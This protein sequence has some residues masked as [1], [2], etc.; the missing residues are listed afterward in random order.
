VVDATEHQLAA[1]RGGDKEARGA[2]LERLR[3]RLVL[4]ASSRMSDRLRARL[5]AEDA[6]Q[7]ILLALHRSLDQFR[8]GDV[9]AFRAWVFT[10]AENRVRDLAREAG[11][12]KRETPEPRAGSA[13]TPSGHAMRNEAAERV[14]DALARLPDDYRRVI[15]LRR[16][17]ELEPAEVAAA[18]DR[19]PN[20]VRI[21]YCRAIQALRKEM[22]DPA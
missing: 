12:L 20:A 15:Q 19:S 14:R 5:T 8:G 1:L 3:P 4:W 10:V 16:F 21:L 11:A 22:G 9:R 2:L 6:A 7:E 17:E 18:L 13:T